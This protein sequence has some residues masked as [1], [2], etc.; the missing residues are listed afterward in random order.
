MKEEETGI[1]LWRH[2]RA[3]INFP[4]LVSVGVPSIIL[5]KFD[6]S[7]NPNY[8][9]F[10]NETKK[11][12][13]V[14]KM[15]AVVCIAIGLWVLIETNRLFHDKGKGTLAPYDPPKHLVVEGP[16]AYVRNPMLLGVYAV[17]AGEVLYFNSKHLLTWLGVI[18]IGTS[19][20]HR[21]FEEKLLLKTF[22]NEYIEYKNNVPFVLPRL[23]PWR[24][25]S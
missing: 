6:Q 7:L 4:L 9:L 17:I 16:Y 23:N 11:R 5:W 8:R 18:I 12:R 2:M 3:I 15:S 14:R 21:F 20:W 1:S 19:L 25:Q 13:M 24:S 10:R 22:G